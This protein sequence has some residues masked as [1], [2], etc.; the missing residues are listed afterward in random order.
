MNTPINEH[1]SLVFV[2]LNVIFLLYITQTVNITYILWKLLYHVNTYIT[3]SFYSS[4]LF[5]YG[6][7]IE[8]RIRDANRN[9][10]TENKLYYQ[11][12]S[13]VFIC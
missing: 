1:Q 5:G 8:R 2:F 9:L 4:K 11:L 13:F 12:F 6:F 7:L 10:K 3:Q